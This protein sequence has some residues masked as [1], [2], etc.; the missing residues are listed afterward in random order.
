MKRQ[1]PGHGTLCWDCANTNRFKCT[2]FDPDDPQPVPGWVATPT[3]VH[4]QRGDTF[5]LI[6]TSLRSYIVHRCPNFEPMSDTPY[7]CDTSKP[8]KNLDTGE[9]YR[10]VKEAARAYSGDG[11][12]ITQACKRYYNAYGCRWAYLEDC[13]T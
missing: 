6:K 10:S 13:I 3:I 5:G 7:M 9:V 2:W 4:S 1:Y 8:V 12:N 11:S